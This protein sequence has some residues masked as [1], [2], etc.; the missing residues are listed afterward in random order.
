[1]SLSPSELSYS[2]IQSI[3]KFVDTDHCHSFTEE[4]DQYALPHW[5]PPLSFMHDF[6]NDT[7]PSNESILEVT[8]LSERPWEDSH[9]RSSSLPSSETAMASFH[10]HISTAQSLFIDLF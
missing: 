4:L 10:P 1:M 9:H 8:S 6:L 2:I 7:L 3:G 5:A